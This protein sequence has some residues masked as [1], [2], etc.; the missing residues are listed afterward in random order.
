MPAKVDTTKCNKNSVAKNQKKTTQKMY[1][2]ISSDEVMENLVDYFFSDN[3]GYQWETSKNGFNLYVEQ[4]P[5]LT[6]TPKFTDERFAEFV[7]KYACEEYGSVRDWLIEWDMLYPGE[8][9][10]EVSTTKFK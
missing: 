1:L 5:E 10:L 9:S 4:F 3:G 8:V 2:R 6:G 7:R